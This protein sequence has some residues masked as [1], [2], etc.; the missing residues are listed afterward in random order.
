[1]NDLNV[2]SRTAIAGATGYIGG[3][4]V[5]QLLSSGYPVRCL[6]RT[7]RKLQDR[8]WSDDPGVEIVQADLENPD[9]LSKTLQDCAFAFYLVH[10]MTSAGSGYAEQDLNLARSFASAA[11]KAGVQRII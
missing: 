2:R 4:L 3:R 8:T 6:V 5:P 10:S 7:P 11:R 1:M 9:S